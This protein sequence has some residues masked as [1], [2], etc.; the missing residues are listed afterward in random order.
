MHASVAYSPIP[1]YIR[2]LCVAYSPM[3]YA[4]TMPRTICHKYAYAVICRHSGRFI[5]PYYIV[6]GIVAAYD[7][8]R[9]MRVICLPT[10]LCGIFSHVIYMTPLWHILAC[11][12]ASVAYSAI[13]NTSLSLSLSLCNM[14]PATMPRTICHKYAYAVICRHTGRIL[15]YLA[16][17]AYMAYY[18]LSLSM[19]QYILRHIGAYR[20]WH[21]IICHICL[22]RII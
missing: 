12:D 21:N 11:Y 9:H 6:R 16:H 13:V 17:M 18:S 1:C 22:C 4:A 7:M 15:Y 2:R 8:T 3:L 20:M 14:P 10:P 19:A 5:L